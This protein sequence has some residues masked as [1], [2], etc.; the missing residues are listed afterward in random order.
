[1]RK[2][3]IPSRNIEE[4]KGIVRIL[5]K[6]QMLIKE[7]KEQIERYD[8]LIKSRFVEMFG[9]PGTNEKGWG[10]ST[11]GKCCVINPKKGQDKRLQIGMEVSFI[12]MP[13]IS[14]NGNIDASEI[15]LYDNV[16]TG[17][18]YFSENDVLFAKITPCMEN[19]KGAVAVGLCNGVGFGSTEFHVIRP[20]EGVSNPY[21]LYGLTSFDTFRKDAAAN[22]TGSAGQKRVPATFLENY[23]VFLPPIKFQTQ[24]ATFVHQVDK[25][26]FYV[27][28]TKYKKKGHTI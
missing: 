8:N 13:A 17:F 25:L 16:K 21:W 11:L 2:M 4:Q 26:K 23:K 14:E 5:N 6:V 18:T 28:K 20:I 7:E 10:A 3:L 19:G 24:F 9:M 27:I 12:P 22:M 1:M 15:R